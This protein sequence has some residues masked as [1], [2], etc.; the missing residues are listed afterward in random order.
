VSAEHLVGASD[1][2]IKRLAE[3]GVIAC[4]LPGTSFYLHKPDHAKARKMLD[5]GVAVTLATD[6]NPGS[7][8]TENLQLIMSFAAV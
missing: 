3:T 5:E 1:G 8:P 6:F 2:G 4:L 7:C